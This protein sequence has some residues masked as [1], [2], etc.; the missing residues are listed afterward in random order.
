MSAKLWYDS[1]SSVQLRP[2]PRLMASMPPGWLRLEAEA[3][4]VEEVEEVAETG[5]GRGG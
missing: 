4:E 1:K 2:R 3:V 5:G